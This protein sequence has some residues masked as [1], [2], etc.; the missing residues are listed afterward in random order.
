[1]IIFQDREVSAAASQGSV[2]DQGL[3]SIFI[4]DL[5]MAVHSEISKSANDI[6][7]Y[8]KTVWMARDSRTI[9]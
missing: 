9:S 8:S 1:M 6:F 4:T 2:L 7:G 3:S 5:E